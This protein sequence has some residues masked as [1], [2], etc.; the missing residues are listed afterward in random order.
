MRK[1]N[2]ISGRVQGGG[3]KRSAFLLVLKYL[4]TAFLSFE[5]LLGIARERGGGVSSW[6]WNLYG[7][8]Q[9]AAAEAVLITKKFIITCT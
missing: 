9:P 8:L 7:W 4:R 2:L 1:S 6:G 3:W 5:L